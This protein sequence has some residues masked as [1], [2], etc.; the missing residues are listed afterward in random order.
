MLKSWLIVGVSLVFLGISGPAAAESSED[1]E[2]NRGLK[3]TQKKNYEAAIAVYEAVLKKQPKNRDALLRVGPLYFL[4]G[5]LESA[6]HVYHQATRKLPSF[7]KGWY[8]YAY[9]L[10]RLGR[11][12]DALHAYGSY[13]KLQRGDP[14]P[15]YG[16]ARCHAALKQ[17]ADAKQA[18]DRFIRLS[19]A[20]RDLA[21]WVTR[22]RAERQGLVKRL[23]VAAA[24]EA[25]QQVLLAARR[26]FQE[27]KLLEAEKL[28][29]A[30]V[31]KYGGSLLL[32]DALADLLIRQQRCGEAIPVLRKAVATKAFPQG[33]YKLALCLRLGR[34]Y[35]AAE[36]A[37]R[38][39]L[40]LVPRHPD[41]HYGLAET[42]RLQ[43]KLSEALRF[44]RAY[45]VIEQRPLEQKWVTKARE[46]ITLLSKQLAAA[47]AP[48]VARVTPQPGPGVQPADPA[49]GITDPAIRAMLAAKR[50]V[51]QRQRGVDVESPAAPASRAAPREPLSRPRNTWAE[52]RQQRLEA[53]RKR[54][55]AARERALERRRQ[56]AEARKRRAEEQ[57]RKREAYLAAQRRK[58]AQRAAELVLRGRSNKLTPEIRSALVDQAEQAAQ[59][60]KS[61]RALEIWQRLDEL[62]PNN[63]KV[64]ESLATTAS[65]AG[66]HQAA[67]GA[68]AKLLKLNPK[69]ISLYSKLRAAQQ[70]AGLALTPLPLKLVLSK[71][72]LAARQALRHGHAEQATTWAKAA[73]RIKPGDGYAYVVLADVQLSL[74]KRKAALAYAAK[75]AQLGPKLAGPYRVIGDYHL[76]LRDRTQ[77]LSNY[78][79]FMARVAGDP[80]EAHN[81]LRVKAMVD[82]LSN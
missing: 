40:K 72:I 76:R 3:L 74:G 1:A 46:T 78:R 27:G 29:K 8:F 13:R 28:L 12:Q 59:K 50:R 71:E 61:G 38:A 53:A 10:R 67:A 64:L 32:L 44:Y 69:D 7:A 62:E 63:A 4:V 39:V 17:Y 43:S 16:M 49:A 56:A 48:P 26:A 45:V 20:R 55:E 18:Y 30:G 25:I 41:A 80:T 31:A 47:K 14:H 34:D 33:R 77:A 75:A 15:F 37:Y 65:A 23:A 82:R 5:R 68:Y 24:A 36:I 79:A 11:Y 42:L 57:R 9:A 81:R 19:A 22:A 73:L 51:E 21:G 52:R 66:N 70:R 58:Q 54:R 2:L 6:R 60:G 35:P